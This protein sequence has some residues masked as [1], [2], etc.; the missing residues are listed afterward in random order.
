MSKKKKIVLGDQLAGYEVA[1][2]PI[3]SHFTDPRFGE[4]NFVK[5]TKKQADIL[6]ANGFPYLKK[7]AKRADNR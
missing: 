5:M 3:S 7:S 2:E 1:V 6:I 4:I